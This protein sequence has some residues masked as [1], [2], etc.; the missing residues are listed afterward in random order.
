MEINVLHVFPETSLKTLASGIKLCALL[1]FLWFTPFSQEMRSPGKIRS[2]SNPAWVFWKY[3]EKF[4]WSRYALPENFLS[5][6]T[7]ISQLRGSESKQDMVKSDGKSKEHF[8]SNFPSASTWICASRGGSAQNM[9]EVD[10]HLRFHNKYTF[11]NGSV[12][13]NSK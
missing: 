4:R 6:L 13:E 11:Y 8:A 9:A 3:S 10:E 1:T 12:I 7:W 5:Y 2:H